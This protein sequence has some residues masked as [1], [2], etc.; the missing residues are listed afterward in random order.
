MKIRVVKALICLV[1]LLSAYGCSE[2]RVQEKISIPPGSLVITNGTI[3][4]GTGASPI[5]D[6]II[7][8][9][10]D[11]IKFIGQ[12]QEFSIP[13]EAEVVDALGQ[14]IALPDSI[15]VTMSEP[16]CLTEV[17]CAATARFNDHR[18]WYTTESPHQES[19]F[20]ASGTSRYRHLRRI[21]SAIRVLFQHLN[22][23]V[24]HPSGRH[25]GVHISGQAKEVTDFAFKAAAER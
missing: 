13:P 7:V 16:L 17:G 15:A 19:R 23:P 18:H 9:Q 21:M 2:Q 3:I 6:G 1:V 12:N 20:S 8:I 25:I 10:D 4:D 24:N 22:H 11:Q 5:Q 14:G